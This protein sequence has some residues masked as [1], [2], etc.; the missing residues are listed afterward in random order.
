MGW[1]SGSLVCGRVTRVF[2]L[3]LLFCFCCCVQWADLGSHIHNEELRE[4]VC[5]HMTIT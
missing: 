5:C 4:E 2:G 1:S 3:L